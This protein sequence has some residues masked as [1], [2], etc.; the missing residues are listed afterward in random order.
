[1]VDTR[2]V[3][4]V[5][6]A[7]SDYG[8][9]LPVLRQLQARAGI[10]LEVIASGAHLLSAFG[11]TVDAIVADGFSVVERVNVLLAEDSPEGIAQSMGLGVS[12]FAQVFARRRPDIL[13]VLGDRFDMHAAAL[14]ALPFRIPVAHLHGGEVTSGAIDDAL[15]HSMTKLSHLHFVATSD[16]ARR[17]AQLGEEPWRIVVTG[18]PALDAIRDLPP[19]SR[20]DLERD[21]GVRLQEAPLL[22]TFHP[23]TLE[24]ENAGEQA[25]ALLG[26]LAGLDRPIVFTMPNADTSNGVIRR[27]ILDWCAPRESAV[28]VENLGPRRYFALMR[29]AAAMVGNSSSGLVEAPSFRLPV[30][31]IGSRQDG[32]LRAANVIDVPAETP[33]IAAAIRRALSP[34]FRA[35]LS[36]LVNPYGDGHAAGRIADTLNDVPLDARLVRKTFTDVLP[37]LCGS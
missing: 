13:V 19:A 30:V 15:R 27:R 4:V 20:D 34:E 33:A 7:R 31:N 2:T 24:Y 32:R 14:A 23:T 8:I 18:A 16:A 21:L 36:S 12:G 28:A 37:D 10:R 1:M 25:D 5:T 11:H 17:V 9:Y 6:V 3:A 35:G 29:H 26:A 22:V